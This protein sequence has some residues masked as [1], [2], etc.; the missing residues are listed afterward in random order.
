[1]SFLYV[2]EGYKDFYN[3]IKQTDGITQVESD[4]YNP[5]SNVSCSSTT[6]FGYFVGEDISEIYGKFSFYV[7]KDNPPNSLLKLS[8]YNAIDASTPICYL[9]AYP[10]D[11]SLT[12]GYFPFKMVL[13]GQN[14]YAQSSTD[15]RHCALVKSFNTV[16]FHIRLASS[17]SCTFEIRFNNNP[18]YSYNFISSY[19]SL[20][21]LICFDL[22]NDVY[23]SN[24][25]MSSDSINANDKIIPLEKTLVS[26]TATSIEGGYKFD[27]NNNYV[28]FSLSNS[29]IPH[30]YETYVSKIVCRVTNVDSAGVDS[31]Q[32]LK[33]RDVAVSSDYTTASIPATGEIQ[34]FVVDVN[35]LS[36][37]TNVTVHS[38][39]IVLE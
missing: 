35:K 1:M 3:F 2:N 16:W 14:L 28:N 5:E 11:S 15:T 10:T 24:V 6:S 34:N 9:E 4:V 39:E 18:I 21:K 19:T 13:G 20:G 30:D 33:F 25:I 23:L 7:N 29:N 27:V 17:G 8:F 26:G 22:L 38:A 37:N 36:A 31:F 12:N 32:Y